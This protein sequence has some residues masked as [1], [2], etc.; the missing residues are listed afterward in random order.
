[1][2][3]RWIFLTLMG[4]CPFTIDAASGYTEVNT[5]QLKELIAN[6]PDLLIVDAR[7]PEHDNGQRIEHAIM[8]PHNSAEKTIT[9][10][11]P[12]KDS[13]IVVY[14]W[15]VRCPMAG[16]MLDR[17]VKMGYNKLYK[18]PEG[19]SVWI[20]EMGPIDTIDQ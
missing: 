10:L 13:P 20:E 7:T 5:N 11:L 16:Y 1:M 3:L 2:M 9:N 15:S 19:L 17:L 8:I 12:K 4:L 14:C 18:Y 6:T